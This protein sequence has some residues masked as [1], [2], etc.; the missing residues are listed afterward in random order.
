MGSHGRHTNAAFAEVDVGL[1][2]RRLRIVPSGRVENASDRTT[3]ANW[4]VAAIGRPAEFIDIKASV[5]TAFRYPNF[6]EL[7]WP[8]Q[9]YLRGN[10]DLSDERSFG[11][12]AGVV[13]HPPR[14]TIEVA[15]FQNYVDNQII[16]VPISAYTIQPINT[17][18]VKTQ[19]V[20]VSFATEPWEWLSL[21]GN[22]TWL[23]ANFRSNGLRLPGRPRHKAN[24]RVEFRY[25]PVTLFGEVQYVGSY[26]LGTANTVYITGRTTANAGAT[27][28][29]AKHFFATFEVKD[30]TNVQIYD[31]RG[32]PLPR[33][34]YWFTMGART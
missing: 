19:G 14:S 26:P 33:R 6:S 11:W 4:R 17:S 7:Y 8:D 9:G 24:A 31:A 28:A 25:K 34:S 29:F 5:G 21:S 18:R 30:A 3:R 27:L 10:P 12:D 16:Y 32:F 1:F 20:E 22:Y 15:Y 23:D 2:D 13:L